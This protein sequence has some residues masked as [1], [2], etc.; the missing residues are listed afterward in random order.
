MTTRKSLASLNAAEQNRYK[1]VINQ[2]INGPGNA[3]GKMVAIHGNMMHDMHGMDATGTQRFLTWHRDYLL[4]L[5]HAMQ[6]IDAQSFIP[7]WNWT[8][9]WALPSWLKSFKPT[10]FVPGHGTVVVTRKPDKTA[11]PPTKAAQIALLQQIPDF[12]TFTDTLENTAH[13]AVHNAMNGTMSDIR[14]SPADPLFWMH[15][16]QID[17]IWSQWQVN[18]PGQNPTLVGAKATMDPWPETEPQ[19][20]SIATL[21]YTY[22]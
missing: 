7:Y 3:Y 21:N 12:T 18:H 14:I 13:G 15:H 16:A 17:R 5:E 6:A 22:Q 1:T 9:K 2:L 4:K 10:V 19:L 20:R 11:P 8:V